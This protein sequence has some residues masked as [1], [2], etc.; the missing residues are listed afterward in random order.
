MR[1]RIAREQRHSNAIERKEVRET[2]DAKA[3][4]AELD[5][6]LGKKQGATRERKRLAKL[7]EKP[8]TS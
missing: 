1:G 8:R 7:I 6:R 3:Q 4:L 2:R 5:R